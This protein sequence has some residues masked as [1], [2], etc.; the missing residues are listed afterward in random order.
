MV[1][2]INET[3]V[4]E[5]KNSELNDTPSPVPMIKSNSE[6]TNLCVQNIVETEE[7]KRPPILGKMDTND[8]LPCRACN[9]TKITSI[10]NNIRSANVKRPSNTPSKRNVSA[11]VHRNSVNKNDNNHDD[12]LKIH[13][14]VRACCENK[15]LDN[16]R[17]PRY[18]GYISQYGLSKDQLETREMNRKKYLEQRARREREIQRAKQQIAHLNEMA[19][20]QWIIRKNHTTR[21]KY[22]NMYDTVLPKPPIKYHSSSKFEKSTRNSS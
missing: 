1:E 22:K 17:L 18:N 6:N 8:N 19:F 10:R 3:I 14:N 20:Q 2:E 9:K 13:L 5:M 15:Y 21:P 11:N 4:N 12:L 7:K 16:N